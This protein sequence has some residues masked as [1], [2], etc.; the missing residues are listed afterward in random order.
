MARRK[1]EKRPYQ[2]RRRAEQTAETRQRIIDAAIDLHTDIGPGRTT[3]SVVAERAGVQRHTLYAHFPDERSLLMACSGETMLR[4][5]LPDVTPW[6]DIARPKARLKTGLRALYDWYERNADLAASVMRDA[7]YDE[8]VREVSALRWGPSIALILGVLG[9]GLEP[10]QMPL[11]QLATG[12]HCW[13]SLVQTSGM[14]HDDAVEAMT[15]A[16]FAKA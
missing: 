7:E 6:R 2:Q 1:A 4:D 10:R 5:P 3:I 12:F 8:L 9:D 13:R 16:V 11:L 15:A 14:S